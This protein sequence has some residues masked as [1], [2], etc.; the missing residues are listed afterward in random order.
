M[1][2]G[3]V[4]M[5][6]EASFEP[7]CQ[8]FSQ[9]FSKGP[10][11]PHAL[12]ALREPC[13]TV[14]MAWR[15]AADGRGL[16]ENRAWGH[17]REV[18]QQRVRAG[19]LGRLLGTWLHAG[20]L[21]AGAVSSPDKGTPQGGGR[22]PMGS[23]VFLHRVLDEWVV[24]DVQPRMQG[25]CFRTRFADDCISGFAREADARRVLDVWP[26]RCARFRRT[27]HPAKTACMAFKRPPSREPSA[28][29]TGSFDCLGFTH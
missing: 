7:E 16:C 17:R 4:G 23:N 15:V 13:R 28:R 25:Q 1:V 10:R 9:G 12:H 3:A 29:G 6:L 14:H 11:Q 19:G 22:S 8:G 26:T 24:K 20:V 21:E 27:M 18:L 5:I 2:Q